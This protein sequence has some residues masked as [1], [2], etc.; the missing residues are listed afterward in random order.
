MI[1]GQG[2][3]GCGA[4]SGA[5]SLFLRGR[6]RHTSAA[7]PCTGIPMWHPSRMR[8]RLRGRWGERRPPGCADGCGGSYRFGVLYPSPKG[9]NTRDFIIHSTCSVHQFGGWFVL[10]YVKAGVG[11]ES[12]SIFVILWNRNIIM[13]LICLGLRSW[14]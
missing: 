1:E 14:G 5:L 11:F 9:Y 13:R 12:L 6:P 3:E 2:R 7:L 8:W 4:P 10:I